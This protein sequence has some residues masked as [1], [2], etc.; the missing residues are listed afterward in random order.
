MWTVDV[1]SDWG[2]R[3]DSLQGIK[4]SLPIILQ[5]FSKRNIKGIFFLS[6]Q[7]LNYYLSMAKMIKNDGHIIGS[8]GHI[9]REWPKSEWWKARIDKEKS[10]EILRGYGLVGSEV[11]YRAPKFSYDSG[12]GIYD[13]PK[14]HVSLLK[15]L[16][17]GTKPSKSSI[18]YLHPFDITEH[19]T[20]SPNLF[21]S[22]LYSQP[23][24]I[25]KLFERYLEYSSD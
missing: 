1:E 3:V 24:R 12:S 7:Y 25:L 5:A 2:G 20:K 23:K 10:I 9:H 16:W 21:C 19:T 11:Y 13:N 18:I 4:E 6:T 8:H 17:F 22:L 14:N 15:S